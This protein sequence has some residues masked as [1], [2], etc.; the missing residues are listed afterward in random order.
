[1][2]LVAV[3]APFVL[4]VFAPVI[5]RVAGPATGW[6]LALFPAA[7]TIFFAQ[8]LDSVSAGGSIGFSTPWVPS[9]GIHLSFY[10]DGLS[11]M[12]ALLISGIG[13]FIVLYAATYL[14]KHA[15]LGRFLMFILMFMGSMLG[16]VLS[17]NVVTFF[18]FW[19]L[20]SITSF[21]L[22]GFNHT[23]QRSRR[24]AVQ[25]LVVTGGGGLALLAGLLLMAQAGGSMELSTLLQSGDLLRDHPH[26]MAILILVLIGAFTKSAQAP[27][28]FWLPNAMEAPTPVSAYLH[29]AT[30]VKAGVYLLARVNPGL[31]GTEV[32]Q[33]IL[34]VFGATT[35]L[36]G[37]ILALR[38]TD[39]KLML[40]Q[41][42]VAS[43]GLLVFLIGLGHELALEAAMA[44]LL[45]HALF[46]GALFMVAGCIDH[47]TGSREV[48]QLSGLRRAMPI[49]FAAAALAA[50]SMSGLPPFIGFIAKEFVYKGTM[51]EFL[52]LLITGIAIL[53][54]ALMFAVA[55][56]VGFKPF[57]GALSESP[58]H[59]HEVSPGLWL[60]PVTLAVLGL[61]AGVFNGVTENALVGPAV[62][63]VGG[64]QV[65]VDL[66]LWGGF[67]LPLFLSIATIASGTLL[68]WKARAISRAMAAAF[69]KLWGPDQ[70]YDQFLD[71]L[72]GTA[73]MVTARLH[74]GTLRDYLLVTMTVVAITLLLPMILIGDIS[75]SLSM[76]QTDFYVWGIALLALASSFTI[77]FSRSRLIAIL[78]MGVL[79]MAVA[80]IFV[81]FSAPDLAFTQLMVE[82]L[83]V[84]ILALV[85]TRLPIYRDDWRGWP[86][87]IRDTAIAGAV[88]TGFTILL[89]SI[90]DRTLDLTL[91]EYFSAFSYTEAY[92][93]NIVN[94]IL[95]DFR[96]F[97]TFGEIAVVVIAGVAVLSLLAM[98]GRRLTQTESTPGVASAKKA[99]TNNKEEDAR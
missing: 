88:G 70:G 38:N 59:P 18:V 42:T 55:F 35:F 52:P 74:T 56:L 95:V 26:Y 72:V 97:D 36:I 51:G 82:T 65:P 64:A 2:L 3:L 40:A 1:M 83:S 60:G 47:G 61:L 84:V 98:G 19:E 50:L 67:K 66:Y 63:A 24:A 93:R 76:P 90:T 39:L 28:H 86:R 48:W 73:R 20:T 4:A 13:A 53:G 29:S 32:W 34:V 71:A 58:K 30:M 27:F 11:L 87:A 37:A 31:G 46:K 49:T 9:L 16:L 78:T 96:A 57:L 41:T 12:F 91:S 62:W 54:N 23:S 75:I 92:G 89:L 17:D 6:L 33:T 45:A 43:L 69:D 79:G 85:I 22:I 68:L 5:R 81:L 80:L 14:A 8:F 21:L 25:A 15:D 77:A 7:L 94:V 44:Y 99:L 10:V